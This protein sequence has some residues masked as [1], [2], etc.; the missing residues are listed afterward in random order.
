[1]SKA[2]GKAVCFFKPINFATS[3]K[4]VPIVAHFSRERESLSIIKMKS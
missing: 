4:T 1:M 2:V 3:E